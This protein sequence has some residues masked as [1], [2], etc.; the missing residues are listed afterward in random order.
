MKPA[1]PANR[2]SRNTKVEPKCDHRAGMMI[3][4]TKGEVIR[5]NCGWFK[6]H[7]RQKARENSAQKHL[8]T[9]HYGGNTIWL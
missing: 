2:V 4:S 1:L 8:D 5:I 6:A 9:H 7:P 3:V